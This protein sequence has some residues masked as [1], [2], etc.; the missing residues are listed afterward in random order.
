MLEI[1]QMQLHA[2]TPHIFCLTTTVIAFVFV[3]E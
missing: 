1:S 3:M 2:G